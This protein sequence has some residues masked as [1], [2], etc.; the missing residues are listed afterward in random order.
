VEHAFVQ[1][2]EL[3]LDT[4]STRPH[5]PG[6]QTD[7]FSPPHAREAQHHRGDELIVATG[8]QRGPFREKHDAQPGDDR[9]LRAAVL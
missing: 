6:L 2:V 1:L 8:Q 9:L 7:E 3:P 5:V 4:D